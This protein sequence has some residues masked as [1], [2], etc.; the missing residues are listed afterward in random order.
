MAGGGFDAPDSGPER[1]NKKY[2]KPKSGSVHIDMTPMV[3]VIML[4]LTFFMLT[5]TLSAP[6]L[7]NVNLPKGDVNKNKVK[8][9]ANQLMFIR[10]SDKG[11]LFVS[12]G[13]E[14]GSETTLE[15]IDVK[16]LST[17][18]EA[19]Y[20]INPDIALILKLDR[21]SKYSL[22]VDIF[23]EVNRSKIKDKRYAIQPITEDDKKMMTDNGG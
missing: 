13:K 21:K 1:G 14:D 4:L 9:A 5:T 15:K 20:Q 8:I 7:M 22:M 6:Q 18:I 2:K 12:K 17:K 19:E 3:D 10:V 16:A 23:D 11:N